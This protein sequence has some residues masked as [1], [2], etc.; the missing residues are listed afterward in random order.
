[1]YE[2]LKD[3]KNAE[4]WTEVQSIDILSDILSKIR[5]REIQYISELNT[6]F[7]KSN[8]GGIYICKK[9]GIIDD[10]K[11]ELKLYKP[12][13]TC[14]FKNK[15]RGN[16][17]VQNDGANRRIKKRLKSDNNFRLRF[18]FA[19][20]FRHHFKNKKGKHTFDILG[21]SVDDLKS[22]LE[23]LFND[24]MC[25]NNYG[26]YWHIDHIKPASMFNHENIDEI[27]EC[28]SLDNLQPLEAS[29][30]MSKGNRYIG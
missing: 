20:L 7:N 18:N 24:N 23:S 3:N 17:K 6:Y 15:N 4:K 9:I 14:I 22:H 16:I 21:Y 13:R 28:W 25:W 11:S 2:G 12:N 19:S 10:I 1:M 29:L 30:N 26:S 8:G 5:N 27:Y